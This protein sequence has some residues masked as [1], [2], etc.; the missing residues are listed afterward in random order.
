ARADAWAQRL[1]AAVRLAW[2]EGAPAPGAL[3]CLSSLLAAGQHEA[4]FSLL[5]LRTIATWPERQFGVRALAAAGRLDEAIAYAQ[6]S[7][8]L[9][10]RRELDI[11]R[12]CEELLLAAGERGRAYAEFAA[13]ANTRQN[14]LQ[15]FKALCARYPEHEPGTI[16]AD[17]IAHKPGEEGKWFATAR[18]LRFFELAAEIAARAPC[19]P[20][21][22]NRAA[23]ERLEVD[24]SYAL[25]LSLASLRWIIEGHGVEIGAA[26]VLR[27]HGLATRAGMLLGGGSRLMARIRAE[28]RGLCELPAPAAAWVRELLADELE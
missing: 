24:P 10:H 17:L 14:C 6:H 22:L 5:E 11:A 18:T 1:T 26:D 23:R 27:A 21:T 7:N 13:A 15:T 8:P 4:L 19:D 16:L 12:T 20:K 2:I 28:I 3:A 9:G 25:E